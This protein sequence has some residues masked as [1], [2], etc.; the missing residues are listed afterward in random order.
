MSHSF[1]QQWRVFPIRRESVGPIFYRC[2]HAR[3]V[4]LGSL[5]GSGEEQILH[6]SYAQNRRAEYNLRAKRSPMMFFFFHCRRFAISMPN[7]GAYPLKVARVKCTGFR[8]TSLPSDVLFDGEGASLNAFEH[9][10]PVCSTTTY[11][12]LNNAL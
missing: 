5:S 1:L 11:W 3:F 2:F 7:G 4:A 6:R 12:F 8:V 9:F 10:N